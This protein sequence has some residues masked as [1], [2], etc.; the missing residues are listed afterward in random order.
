LTI[1]LITALGCAGA[2]KSTLPATTTYTISGTVTGLAGTGLILQDNGGNNLTV[3]ASATNFSFAT[4]V[5]SGAAYSVAL[6]TQP[7]GQS[8]AVTNGS[9]TATA[10]VTNVSVICTQVYTIGGAVTGLTGTGLVLQDNGGNNLT[11]S[12]NATSFIFPTLVTNGGAYSV[13]VLTQPAEESCAVTSGSGTAT[14]NITNVSVACT[15]AYTIGGA[16]AGLTGSGLV[17][18][19]NGVNNLTVS[20]NA[21]SFTLATPV[22]GGGAYSVTVLTQPTGQSCTVFNGSGTATANVTSVIVSCIQ[23]Y[24]I[25]GAVTGLTGTGLVIEDNGGDNLTVSANATGFTF[26]TPV[27]KGDAYSVALLTQPAGQNCA[28][29]NG[30]GTATANITNVSVTCTQ[31]Y[32]IDGT[33]TGLTGTG[34]VLQDNGGNDLMVSANATSFSFATPVVSGGA[35]SV[36][37]LTQPANQSCAVTN[38]SGTATAVV[39]DVS[40]V[41]VGE[42][43]WSGGSN[44]VGFNGGQTGVYGTLGAPSPTN[45]PGGRNQSTTWKDASG[46]IWLFGG[47]GLDSVGTSGVL[48]DLWK[49]DPKLGTNGEWTWMSGST[50]SPSTLGLGVSHGAP[51]V[52]GT[53]GT[54]SPINVPGGRVDIMSWKD[55]SGNLWLFG[56]N[57]IDSNGGN[58]FLS[59]LWKF[60][61]KLGTNGEWVWMGG[62]NTAR[63]QGGQPGV[64]GTLGTAAA[65]NI[66]G[67]RYGGVTWTD[68]SGNFWL[69]GGMGADS[70]GTNGFLSDLWEYTPGTNGIAGNWTWQGGSNT[71]PP[72]AGQFDQPGDPGVYGTLGTASPTNIP[73]GRD[74]A[75]TWVD[76]SGKTWLFGGLGFDSAGTNGYLN[77]LWMFDP[78]LGGTGE[79]TWMGGSNIVGSNGGQPGV[80]GI[81]GTTAS[82]NA[83]GARFSPASWIDA[84]GNLWLFGGQGYDWTGMDGYLNDLWKYTPGEA[85]NP[86]NWTWMGGSN[87]VPPISSQ[88]VLQGPLGVYG[89]LGTAA[90]TNVVGGRYGAVSWIDASG[91]LWLFGGHGNDSTGTQGNLN[92]L[93]QYQP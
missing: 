28:V 69:F 75:V 16:I 26:A 85:G 66:P 55:A 60:D 58:G 17:L 13:T 7:A 76:A 87:T 27:T 43:T 23:T 1:A 12:A 70:V 22:T 79:W 10:N 81:L 71:L 90:S 20:S 25:G 6:L 32:T 37:V 40:V 93:W 2:S 52:Y 53:L 3:G 78:K 73:G 41:C 82:A 34:L 57:G 51:G 74:S 50:I 89:I 36:T 4:P 59:D 30:S 21:T 11:V 56:G 24:T 67:G 64:Y 84:S 88:Y 46:N 33:V 68:A 31:A 92:D 48:N 47:Q 8:C 86:G 15:Q 80:Y 63:Q 61:L 83:P 65:T 54:A 42:W 45:T 44:F 39:A 29:T 49:F 9:C 72:S 62:S 91:N 19:D 35:Y 14:A 5:T 77:D 38:G 18:Q